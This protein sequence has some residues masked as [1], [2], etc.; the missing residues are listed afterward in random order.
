MRRFILVRMW[1]WTGV[2]GLSNYLFRFLHVATRDV[3]QEM[4]VN[5]KPIFVWT[6]KC[7]HQMS[8]WHWPLI[9]NK[10]GSLA[11]HYKPP[12]LSNL[13]T[14]GQS[15]LKLSI[16]KSFTSIMVDGRTGGHVIVRV[17]RFFEGRYNNTVHVYE[18]ASYIRTYM[19][20]TLWYNMK[21]IHVKHIMKLRLR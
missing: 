10:L 7:L 16:G 13:R 8:Y 4:F 12:C 2:V 18:K 15:I 20:S 5:V 17:S 11:C 14:G 21:Y 1:P 19:N 6:L 9:W 3:Q